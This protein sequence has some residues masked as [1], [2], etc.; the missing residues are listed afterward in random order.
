LARIV[1]RYAAPAS[2]DSVGSPTKGQAL[3]KPSFPVSKDELQQPTYKALLSR[4][5]RL[6]FFTSLAVANE[7]TAKQNLPEVK[8]PI[9]AAKL[10]QPE[11]DFSEPKIVT[12]SE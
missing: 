4:P 10:V 12:C 7:K 5:H 8:R 3:P 1:A 11:M 2:R 6:A 9:R